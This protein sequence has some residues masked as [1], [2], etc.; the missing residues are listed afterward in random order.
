MY[1]FRKT[2]FA[3]AVPFILGCATSQGTPSSANAPS[4]PFAANEGKAIKVTYIRF[5]WDDKARQFVGTYRIMLSEGWVKK[6]GASPREPFPRVFPRP[7]RGEG[8]PDS[9]MELLISEM[10][11]FGLHDLN[12][13]TAD[14]VDLEALKRVERST[15][16]NVVAG[17]RMIN[18]ETDTIRKT[19]IA[20]DNLL[21][22][23]QKFN[24]VETQVVRVANM[25]T[26]QVTVERLP[27][28][29]K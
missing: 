28:I 1:L 14:R 13:T 22:L 11:R 20:K 19:V 29:P 7:Y 9:M 24:K 2:V 8:I 4:D 6:Y 12:A 21:E 15:D 23:G 17:W 5:N 10:V 3:L 16:Y 25:Y 27:T 18:I 26:V